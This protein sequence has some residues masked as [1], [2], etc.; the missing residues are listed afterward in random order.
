[1]FFCVRDKDVPNDSLSQ[2]HVDC[3]KCHSCHRAIGSDKYFDTPSGILCG[4]C[5]K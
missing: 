1:M 4:S 3:F 5:K 2:Y